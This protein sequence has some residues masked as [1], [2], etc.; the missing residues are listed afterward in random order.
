MTS[1]H[2]TKFLYKNEEEI[3][4]QLRTEVKSVDHA[5]NEDFHDFLVFLHVADLLEFLT[6]VGVFEI[7]HFHRFK[8]VRCL[9]VIVR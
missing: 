2:Q 6:D 1:E 8:L 5:E 7:F 3:L 4:A 9:Q